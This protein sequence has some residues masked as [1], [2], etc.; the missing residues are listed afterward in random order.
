PRSPRPEGASR[1]TTCRP[2][3]RSTSSFAWSGS[4]RASRDHRARRLGACRMSEPYL[5]EIRLFSFGFAPK[6]WALCDGQ[7]LSISQNQA[8]FALIGRTFGGDGRTT[9][10]LP[11]LRGRVPLHFNGQFTVGERAGEEAHTLTLAELPAH[12]H[13]V[14]ASSSIP[15]RPG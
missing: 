4:F 6:G 5:A 15:N 12:T 14:I 10:G 9:F 8:L 1:T 3:S 2:S 13:T 7:L 11:D